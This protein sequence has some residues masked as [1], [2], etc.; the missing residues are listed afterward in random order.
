MFFGGND[1]TPNCLGNRPFRWFVGR[2]AALLINFVSFGT[3]CPAKIVAVRRRRV[4]T[5][6]ATDACVNWYKCLNSV[7][8]LPA[9]T[10]K[11][12]D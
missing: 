7:F 3:D 4:Y 6:F 2:N 10:W 1:C 12:F 5:I 9:A 11:S 8:H